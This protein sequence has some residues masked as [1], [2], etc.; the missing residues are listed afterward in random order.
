MILGLSASFLQNTYVPIGS[1][2]LI[3]IFFKLD[4]KWWNEVAL[5]KRNLTIHPESMLSWCFSYYHAV[6]FIASCVVCVFCKMFTLFFIKM[7]SIHR[8]MSIL[9]PFLSA[10]GEHPPFNRFP[11]SVWCH[12]LG[13]LQKQSKKAGSFLKRFNNID[14]DESSSSFLVKQPHSIIS[15]RA[16]RK[17]KLDKNL[18]MGRMYFEESL[19]ISPISSWHMTV[20]FAAVHFHCAIV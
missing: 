8:V 7:H 3:C 12:V 9:T 2:Y 16:W 10:H 15:S 6:F 1:F 13:H 5:P 18:P 4:L 19:L 14:L 20:T 11:S 17:C